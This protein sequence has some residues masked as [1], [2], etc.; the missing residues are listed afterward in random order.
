MPEEIAKI[1]EL[2]L[3]QDNRATSYPIFIIVEDV[4][5]YGVDGNFSMDGRERKEE[6]DGQLCESCEK[7]GEEGEDLPEDCE[8]CSDDCFITYRIEKDVP[9]LY[10]AFFF[11]A[12]AAQAHLD[13]NHHHYNSTAH[14]YAIS[15]YN[16]YELRAVMQHLCG[17]DLR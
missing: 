10:A 16:N 12:E 13:V 8:F 7:L 11:T 3:T 15:A 6:S 9:N 5:I 14:T 4:R 1:K 2:M 17:K